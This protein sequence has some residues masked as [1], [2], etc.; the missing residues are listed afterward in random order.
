MQKF[1]Y[2]LKGT[3]V[4]EF[5]S[6]VYDYKLH[7]GLFSALTFHAGR[8]VFC[9]TTLSLVEFLPSARTTVDGQ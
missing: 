5:S 8:G 7:L 3:N 6:Y 4:Y 9:T 1:K 2:I